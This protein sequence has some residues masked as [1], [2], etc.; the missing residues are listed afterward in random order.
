VLNGK[1][2]TSAVDFQNPPL[3]DPYRARYRTGALIW[4]TALL[5][6]SLQPMRPGNIHFG[7]LHRLAHFLCFGALAFLG[8]RGFLRPGRISLWPASEC[9]IF[10]LAIEFLQHCQN[11]MSIEWNDVRDDALGIL[12]FTVLFYATHRSHAGTRKK[13]V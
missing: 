3:G 2:M 5:I 7:L 11:R 13:E 1:S 9:F 4:A 6:L 10:G 8:T 12:A